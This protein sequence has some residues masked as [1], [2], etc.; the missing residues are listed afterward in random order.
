LPIFDPKKCYK[1]LSPPYSPP[2]YFLFPKLKIKL[3][4]LQFADVADIQEAVTDELKNVQ[5]RGI[6]GSFSETVRQR[7]KHVYMSMEL[8]LN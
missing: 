8:I 7:K 3:K 4:V 5:K 2:E 6:F 1:H